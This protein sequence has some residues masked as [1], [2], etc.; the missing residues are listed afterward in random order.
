[1]HISCKIR[2]ILKVYF[3]ISK[4][5]LFFHIVNVSDLSILKEKG[6]QL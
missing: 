5:F 6:V 3:V 4:I 2:E 1:M